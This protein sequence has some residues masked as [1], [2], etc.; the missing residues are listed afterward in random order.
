MIKKLLFLLL[1]LA[2]FTCFINAQSNEP[3]FVGEVNLLN[4]DNM[5][6]LEK[7][8]AKIKTKAGASMYLVGIG[9]IK[10][11]INVK[12]STSKVRVKQG[13]DFKLIIKAVDNVSDPM[14]I[15]N[16]F[17]FD[18]TSSARKAELSSLATFGGHNDNKLKLVEYTAKKYGE[19]SYLITLKDAPSGEFGI[20]VK[21]PNNKDEKNIVVACFGIDK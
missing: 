21:N 9:S 18:V 6:A 11:K 2:N 19:S 15:I 12:G 10:T 1:L 4:G 8:Y 3:D 16:I 13:D 14:S 5:T 17:Q 7:E 20:T